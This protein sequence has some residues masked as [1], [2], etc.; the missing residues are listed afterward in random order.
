M[1]L[2]SNR[3]QQNMWDFH[4]NP[5]AVRTGHEERQML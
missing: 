4:V 5:N 2:S 1:S 3:G